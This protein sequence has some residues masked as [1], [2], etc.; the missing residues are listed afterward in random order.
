[1]TSSRI[2][3]IFRPAELAVEAIAHDPLASAADLEQR[4]DRRSALARHFAGNPALASLYIG[5]PNGDFVLMRSLSDNGERARFGAPSGAAY[6]IQA[7]MR[8][9][10]A[11]L[12]FYDAALRE[13]GR[14]P[15]P[16]YLAYDPRTRP[17]F[18]SALAHGGVIRTDPYLFFTTREVGTTVALAG[19]RS[20]TSSRP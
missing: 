1:V 13:I 15:E 16:G 7:I 9:Q 12:V 5:Y 11:E 4:L 20:P 6:L 18:R 10:T 17:W 19:A 3:D 8:P 2:A 14:R